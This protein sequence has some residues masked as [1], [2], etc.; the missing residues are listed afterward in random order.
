MLECGEVT[1]SAA[2]TGTRHGPA[3]LHPG[4]QLMNSSDSLQL[5]DYLARVLA[6]YD[7]GLGD[8]DEKAPTLDLVH[9][10]NP[11][12]SRPNNSADPAPHKAVNEGSLSDL[13]PDHHRPSLVPT[14]LFTTPIPGPHRV[15]RYE[16]R[17]QLGK[18][19]CGI[20]FL[21]YDPKLNREVALKI[22]R[23]EMLT[24]EDARRRLAREARAAAEFDHPNLVPV[25]ETGEIG[26][27]CYIT[28]AFCPGQTLAEWLDRQAFPVPVRQAAR[29][30]AQVAE[31]VQ[32]AHDRGVLHRDLKPNNVILQPAKTDPVDQGPPIG[33]CPLR[34]DH[35]IPR[36]VDFGLAKLAERGPSET[37]TRQVLG[38]P[39]YMS[40]EQAQA[41]H[42][43]VGPQADVYALGVVL[44]EMLA[45][46]APYDGP[47]DV[48]VL[49]Q[50]V[51][52]RLT[53]PRDLRVDIPRDLEAICLKAMA[54]TPGK[55]YRTAIDLADDLRRF[56]DGRP[57]LAR[58]L[59]RLGR[60]ARWL[61]RND[62]LVALI[63]VSTVAVILLPM[64]GWS[65]HQNQ[66]LLK[67]QEGNQAQNDVR[68]RQDRQREYARHVRDAFLSWRA[69]DPKQMAD[70]LARADLSSDAGELGEFAW[71]YLS[72]LGRVERQSV[73]C[74][75]G[76]TV[77]LAV[78]LDGG[79]LATG[80]ADGTLTVWDRHTGTP[81]GSVKAHLGGV[82]H[83]A[84]LAGGGLVT[85]GREPI[86]RT[87]EVGRDGVPRPGPSFPAL[88]AAVSV[89][90][91]TPD[92]TGVYVGSTAG[93]CLRWDAITRQAGTPWS[94]TGGEPVGAVA[95]SPDGKTLATAGT[96]EPVRL[97][98]TATLNP[99]GEIRSAVAPGVLVF[100]PAD[101]GAWLLAAE[102]RE[103]GTI[104][105]FDSQG[106][107]VRTLPGHAGTVL[108]LAV[109]PDGTS[110]A[111]GGGD[112]GVC[113]WD[114]TTGTARALF[115]GHDQPVRA[116]R[117]A[118]DGR[119]LFSAGEDGLWKAWDLAADPEGPVVR[120]LSAAVTGLAVRPNGTE[121][122]VA[123]ADGS[124]DTYAHRGAAPQ[125]IP[126]DT[127]G[128]IGVLRIPANGP[129]L[130][131][132]IGGR[133]AVVWS[134]GPTRQIHFRA[135]IPVPARSLSRPEFPGGPVATAADLSATGDRLVVGDDRGRVTIWSTK[136]RQLIGEF[137]TGLAA[138]VR[139]LCISDDGNWVAAQTTDHE[140]G[141]WEVGDPNRRFRVAGHGDGLW[142]IRFLPGGQRLVTA[143]RGSSIKVWSVRS[144]REELTLLGHIGRVTGLTVSPNGRTL[145]SGSGTG[146]VKLWDLR[147]G[148][149][150]IG[151]RR[152]TGPVSVAEFA[153]N[154]QTL[155]TAGTTPGGRGELAFWE[156]R[157]P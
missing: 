38:T 3:T 53:P 15:G 64:M 116:V 155:I 132:E 107:E 84:F 106:R 127:H 10:S 91:P 99:I 105:L 63:V 28:T 112:A 146:E 27:V 145:V 124:I 75:A 74:P 141:V 47:T 135:E 125:R 13:L 101:S 55:R 20:V 6:A 34:G 96:T 108:A 49:R 121:F 113:V 126:A 26:P 143:G 61:R 128:P 17:R 144:E 72:Q 77:V 147:T 2:Q 115:R 23:P 70:S 117:F 22:P 1:E 69:G 137:D 123:L 89:L 103:D 100:A 148:Q 41:R 48:E 130:G 52:G 151:L 67:V 138:P 157:V 98:D 33:S 65:I 152:H 60:A 43:D 88:S 90:T 7:Q 66:K 40:P 42:E 119:T 44:Y 12:S 54:R 73:V 58:P 114:V 150:L 18:G 80:H 104:R 86:A 156:A 129:P 140:V 83:A 154:G 153:G 59:N 71:G 118:P 50:A 8:G 31:A 79:R 87:W 131:V 102:G 62:Q 25:Y 111:S 57:T 24:S 97:W 142:L 14:S 46:R 35:F 85:A 11:N 76:P 16:L 21:A 29:L 94:A 30:I 51:E 95:V 109:S 37:V 134:F 93:E 45:G 5:D 78:S 39:K 122:I 110:I 56:L 19:G 36:V 120:G 9:L 32:H 82:T 81:L 4:I 139:H 149:E 136:D 133:A 68:M 92:G